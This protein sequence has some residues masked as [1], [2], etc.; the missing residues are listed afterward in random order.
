VVLGFV[1]AAASEIAATIIGLFWEFSSLSHTLSLSHCLSKEKGFGLNPKPKPQWF[2]WLQI[3][4]FGRN[5]NGEMGLRRI[6]HFWRPLEPE[7][8]DEEALQQCDI[9]WV[10]RERNR[11]GEG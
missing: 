3:K 7:E 9:F 1:E 4:E 6:Q 8:D 11:V 2:S 5:A 10:L